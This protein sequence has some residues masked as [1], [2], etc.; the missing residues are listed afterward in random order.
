MPQMKIKGPGAFCAGP[1]TF[2][3]AFDGDPFLLLDSFR[4][5]LWKTQLQDPVLEFG[6]YILL[7]EGVSYIEASLHSPCVTLLADVFALLIFL[8]LVQPLAAEM[9]R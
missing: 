7:S 8:V 4:V 3:L 2:L 1:D 9:V 6:L 5:L